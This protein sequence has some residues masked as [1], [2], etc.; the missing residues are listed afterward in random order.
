MQLRV[1]CRPGL[2]DMFGD[3]MAWLS[4]LT[5]YKDGS[6][7]ADDPSG[8]YLEMLFLTCGT[9]GQSFVTQS[10]CFSGAQEIVWYVGMAESQLPTNHVRSAVSRQNACG[11]KLLRIVTC[12]RPDE[13]SEVGFVRVTRSSLVSNVVFV[14][15]S[16]QSNLKFSQ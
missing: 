7:G 16:L 11:H 1:L 13:V 12:P 9:R 3:S 10:V 15:D 5:T 6:R 4:G 14:N 8:K 2:L